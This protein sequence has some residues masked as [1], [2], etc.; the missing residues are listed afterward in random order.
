MKEASIWVD[1]YFGSIIGHSLFVRTLCLENLPF[2]TVSWKH[3]DNSYFKREDLP[4]GCCKIKKN[5]MIFHLFCLGEAAWGAFHK[6]HALD[7][8]NFESS[9]AGMILVIE[10]QSVL[11]SLERKQIDEEKISQG[12]IDFSWFEKQKLLLVIAATGYQGFT[13][14]IENLRDF[15]EIPVD[16]PI[17]PGPSMWQSDLLQFDSNY[18][19]LVLTVLYEKLMDT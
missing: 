1:Q 15:L 8:L 12:G 11:D 6:D 16:I 10:R 3:P 9:L 14:E 2:T 17:I 4:L 5:Q 18:A 13:S 7:E 19:N